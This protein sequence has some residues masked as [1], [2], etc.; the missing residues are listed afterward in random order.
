MGGLLVDSR[1]FRYLKYSAT[2]ASWSSS[3]YIIHVRLLRA[4]SATLRVDQI[5]KSVSVS[6]DPG[7]FNQLNVH[8]TLGDCLHLL[9]NSS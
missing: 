3:D 9:R 4:G 8:N 2:V 5:V 7:H 1:Q 6:L